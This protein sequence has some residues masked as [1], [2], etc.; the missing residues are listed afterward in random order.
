[1]KFKN[2]GMHYLSFQVVSSHTYSCSDSGCVPLDNIVNLYKLYYNNIQQNPNC[3]VSSFHS[4]WIWVFCNGT[5]KSAFVTG[6][7]SSKMQQR[8]KTIGPMRSPVFQAPRSKVMCHV[9]KSASGP[10]FY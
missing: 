6:N 3:F 9:E 7:S 4:W 8:V 10:E 5:K 2:L 1:M